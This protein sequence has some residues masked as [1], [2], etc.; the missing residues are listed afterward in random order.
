MYSLYIIWD[1]YVQSVYGQ[2]MYSVCVWAV[3]GVWVEFVALCAALCGNDSELEID[4][5]MD[6]FPPGSGAPRY[7]GSVTPVSGLTKP[8]LHDWPARS[9]T[10]RELTARCNHTQI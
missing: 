5:V 2:Y 4:N 10:R 8:H 7:D 1:V 6:Q 9:R 3:Y